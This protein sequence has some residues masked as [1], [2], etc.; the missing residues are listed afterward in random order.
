[1]TVDKFEF[2]KDGR[3]IETADANS[4]G[5]PDN[6][7]RERIV[8][9]TGPKESPVTCDGTPFEARTE[10]TSSGGETPSPASSGENTETTDGGMPAAADA[11]TTDAGA[12]GGVGD[13]G[14]VGADAGPDG[15][16]P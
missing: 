2:F 12:D 1:G 13:G 9:A 14:T 16:T 3:L 10:T 4:E 6:E 11:G 8:Q 7:S 5:R 15:G